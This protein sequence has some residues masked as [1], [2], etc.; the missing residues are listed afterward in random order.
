MG[1][2]KYL[3]AYESIYWLNINDHIEKLIQKYST[4]CISAKSAKGDKMTHK[5]P[6]K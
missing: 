1:I 5:I 4:S 2:E 6:I 3:L